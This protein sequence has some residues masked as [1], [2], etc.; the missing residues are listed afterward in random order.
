MFDGHGINGQ[1]EEI[2][3]HITQTKNCI[4]FVTAQNHIQKLTKSEITFL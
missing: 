4:H 2:Q 1:I 3:Q